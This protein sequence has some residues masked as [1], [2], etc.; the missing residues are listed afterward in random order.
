MP[1]DLVPLSE[2]RLRGEPP[3]QLVCGRCKRSLPEDAFGVDV[4]RSTGRKYQCRPCSSEE[5]RK[6]REGSAAYRDRQD[7]RLAE[8][9]ELR[10][11]DPKLRWAKRAAAASRMRAKQAN[12]FSS[13]TVEWLVANSPDVCPL[14]G[15]PLRYD[16]SSSLKD[17]AALDR[18]DNTK[19]YTPDN[20]W[21][22]SMH[23]N[24]IKSNATVDEIEQVAQSLRAVLLVEELFGDRLIADIIGDHDA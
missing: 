19:G 15:I 20:C 21:V 16:N 17:S 3:H 11:S 8:D 22:I 6:W 23:A 12:S 5:Y 7:R 9:R 1:H 4:R 10:S 2:C 18:R 14:L 24:R 13:I